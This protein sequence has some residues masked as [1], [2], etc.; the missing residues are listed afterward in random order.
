MTDPTLTWEDDGGPCAADGATVADDRTWPW[1]TMPPDLGEV[2]ARIVYDTATSSAARGDA[3]EDAADEMR[4][5]CRDWGDR[6]RPLIVEFV[7]GWIGNFDEDHPDILYG[8]PEDFV[9]AWREEMSN[10]C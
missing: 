6:Y 1:R 10:A 4:E 7:A 9:D 3:F 2:L 5:A 8:G